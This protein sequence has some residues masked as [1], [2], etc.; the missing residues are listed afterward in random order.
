LSEAV[1]PEYAAFLNNYKDALEA[2]R[3]AAQNSTQFA[4]LTRRMKLRT[5]D[6]QQ[7]Q[8][9]TTTL[10]DLLHKPVAR[11]QRHVAIIKACL[12]VS[13][14]PSGHFI[15]FSRLCRTSWIVFRQMI[16]AIR[17]SRML[18]S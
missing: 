3:K 16:R 7:Q 9:Q 14:S 11:V 1:L 8:Q 6:P 4:Q 2:T 5:K 12:I 13:I 15:R 17:S 10:E 18:N